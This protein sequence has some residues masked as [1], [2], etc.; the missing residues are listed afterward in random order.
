MSTSST[1]WYTPLSFSFNSMW[2]HWR[3]FWFIKLHTILCSVVTFISQ[4]IIVYMLTMA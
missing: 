1:I 4:F 3:L 2:C